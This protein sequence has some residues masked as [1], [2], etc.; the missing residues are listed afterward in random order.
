C[1][2]TSSSRRKLSIEPRRIYPLLYLR[3]EFCKIL[4]RK[5]MRLDGLYPLV[6]S[7][8]KILKRA[9]SSLAP[10]EMNSLDYSGQNE[11]FDMSSTAIRHR[12]Q[13][14]HYEVANLKQDES[15]DDDEYDATSENVQVDNNTKG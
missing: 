1:I 11:N 13:D 9:N 10:E 6:T 5:P 3:Q 7:R 12:S 2:M 15:Y 4:K 14:G 8:V